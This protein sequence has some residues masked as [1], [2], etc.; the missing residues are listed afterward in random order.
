MRKPSNLKQRLD[1]LRGESPAPIALELQLDAEIYRL[2]QQRAR[3]AQLSTESYIMQ[4]LAQHL[5][6]EE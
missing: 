5:E 6:T 4:V 1:Q 2:L 3:R